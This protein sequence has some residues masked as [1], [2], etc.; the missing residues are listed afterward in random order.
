MVR[1]KHDY[2]LLQQKIKEVYKTNEMF[3]KQ[4]GISYNT[5]CNY[6]SNKTPISSDKIEVIRRA[7]GIKDYEIN[8]Y[9]FVPYVSQ[10]K[11]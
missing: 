2:S 10:V 9:F 3:A 6:L 11:G 5:V 4:V 1:Y 7:L 8:K